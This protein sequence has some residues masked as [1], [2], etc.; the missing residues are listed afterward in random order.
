MIGGSAEDMYR[1]MANV[2]ECIREHRKDPSQSKI[3]RI[4]G[5]V[6]FITQLPIEEAFRSM[7]K[8]YHI[9]HRRHLAP[10]IHEVRQTVNLA[11]VLVSA[12]NLKLITF[13]GDETL[14]PNGNNF[15]DPELA[16]LITQLLRHGCHVALV[17]A[18]GY[19]TIPTLYEKRLDVLVH[20]LRM[21]THLTDEEKQHFWVFGGEANYLFR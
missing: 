1:V 3:T 6:D 5:N 7:D 19:G 16:V 20:T 2:E 11:Q 9:T 8:K 18:A 12:K 13:D 17:T 10:S 15:S 21:D 4:L 14:Y